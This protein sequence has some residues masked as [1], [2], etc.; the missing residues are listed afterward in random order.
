VAVLVPIDH[1]GLPVAK[2]RS[3]KAPAAVRGAKNR[4][5]RLVA[6][7]HS[8]PPAAKTHWKMLEATHRYWR[9][10][11]VEE[12]TGWPPGLSE[13]PGSFEK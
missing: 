2:N 10:F 5:K 13:V 12:P 11:G 7:N 6:T 8:P 3:L 1:S 9:H 4:S